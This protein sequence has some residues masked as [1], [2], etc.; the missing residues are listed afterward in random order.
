[1]TDTCPTPGKTVPP[2]RAA[3]RGIRTRLRAA[4]AIPALMVTALLVIAGPTAVV[5]ASAAGSTPSPTPTPT[6]GALTGDDGLHPVAHRERHV[7]AGEGLA[8]SVTSSERDGCRNRAD[9]RHPVARHDG[10][11]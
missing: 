5:P 4:I 3:R 7:R 6:A 10:T 8:V 11:A 1:M 9:R 2:P